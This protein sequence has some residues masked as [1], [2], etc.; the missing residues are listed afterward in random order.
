MVENEN[1]RFRNTRWGGYLDNS[2]AGGISSG[3]SKFESVVKESMEEASISEDIVRRHV[4]SVGSISYYNR[5]IL[6]VFYTE[7]T[8]RVGRTSKGWLQPEVQ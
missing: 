4:R 3:M 6:F 5:C 8:R 2:V 7:L 1:S